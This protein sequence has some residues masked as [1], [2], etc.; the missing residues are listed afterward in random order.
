MR[1]RRK[2]FALFATLVLAV[3]GCGDDATIG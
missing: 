2:L 3:A 1:L